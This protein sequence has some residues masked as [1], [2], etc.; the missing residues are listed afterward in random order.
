MSN[1]LGVILKEA[2]DKQDIHTIHRII[3]EMN[4]GGAFEHWNNVANS[5]FNLET[6]YTHN[7]ITD[8]CNDILNTIRDY[9]YNRPVDEHEETN[10]ALQ[11]L[12]MM[13]C[14]SESNPWPRLQF[15]NPIN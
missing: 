5:F 2:C 8:L 10:L 13:L 9:L 1:G 4:I 14:G 7:K 15:E 11:I 3:S 6:D 12:Q